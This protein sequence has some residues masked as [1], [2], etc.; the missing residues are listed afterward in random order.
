MGTCT[1]TH[2]MIKDC[3]SCTAKVLA[4]RS[5]EEVE[6]WWAQGV[7]SED[8]LEAYRHVW[9]LSAPRSKGYAHWTMLPP[10]DEGRAIAAALTALLPSGRGYA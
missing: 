4:T 10:T 7:I 8:A 6:N 9:A 3:V 1:E 5:L 2:L